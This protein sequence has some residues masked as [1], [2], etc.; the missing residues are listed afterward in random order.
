MYGLY[1]ITFL[2]HPLAEQSYT[3]LLQCCV[4]TEAVEIHKELGIHVQ[5]IAYNFIQ[6]CSHGDILGGYPVGLH[7]AICRIRFFEAVESYLIT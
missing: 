5:F 6:T 2:P 7:D 1:P 3:E 4:G